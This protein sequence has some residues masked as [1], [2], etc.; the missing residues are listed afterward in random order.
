M[1]NPINV[2][3]IFVDRASNLPSSTFSTSGNIITNRE[4]EVAELLSGVLQSIVNS[5]SHTIEVETTLDY[6]P[7][8]SELINEGDYENGVEDTINPE[9]SEEED[10][11]DKALRKEFSLHYMTRAVNFYDGINP[12][13]GKRKRRWETMKHNFQRIP[14]QT[15]IARLRHYLERHETTKAET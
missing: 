7:S 10:D 9:W 4:Y 13:T 14:H 11:E 1:I 5:H 15:D 8:E 3:K 12:K 2:A 6:E